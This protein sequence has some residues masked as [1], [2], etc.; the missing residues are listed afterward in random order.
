[1]APRLTTKVDAAHGIWSAPVLR[2][3]RKARSAR[4]KLNNRA[5]RSSKAP[6]DRRIPNCCEPCLFWS[7][8]C[9]FPIQWRQH[10]AAVAVAAAAL[11][12]FDPIK[13]KSRS[14]GKDEN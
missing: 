7:L 10:R 1:M 6:E 9:T 2:R 5:P 3:F 12:P 4:N 11:T 8:P 13:S 14:C